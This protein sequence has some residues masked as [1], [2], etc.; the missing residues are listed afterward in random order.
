MMIGTLFPALR[1]SRQTSRPLIF[2]SMTSRMISSGDSPV[3]RLSPAAP[4]RATETAYPSYS[5][6]SRTAATLEP[7]SSTIRTFGTSVPSFPRQRKAHAG[8]ANRQDGDVPVARQPHGDVP[9][10]S[11]VFD[12]IVDQIVQRLR[13]RVR[14]D[15]DPRQPI[16]RVLEGD[17][18]SA[19]LQVSLERVER[20]LD[21]FAQIGIDEPVLLPSRLDA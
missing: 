17:P 20:L 21:H 3:A 15:R 10:L 9:R 11:R 16:L 14:I 1:I 5:N 6:P 13:H 18:E 19:V 8:I 7:S 2:G 12:G 4:S